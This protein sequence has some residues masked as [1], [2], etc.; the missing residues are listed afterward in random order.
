MKRLLALLAPYR[1]A[2]VAA[3]VSAVTALAAKY[4]LDLT[5]AQTSFVTTVF[6]TLSV[7]LVPNG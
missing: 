4:G 7:Y 2:V 6:T 5:A 1:K 3:A